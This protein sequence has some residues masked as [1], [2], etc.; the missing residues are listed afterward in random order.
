[1]SKEDIDKQPIISGAGRI[2]LLEDD[3]SFMEFYRERFKR[4]GFEVFTEDDEDE[5]MDLALSCNPE[6][7]ILDISLPKNDDFD[8]ISDA[9]KKAELVA[10]PIVILTDLS[11]D[12]SRRRGMS[13]GASDYLVREDMSFVDIAER[14]RSIIEKNRK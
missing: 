9:R 6:L 7:I 2:L 5:G 1:M 4:F 12:E 3:P 10:V 13:A 8:F 11:D 14:I